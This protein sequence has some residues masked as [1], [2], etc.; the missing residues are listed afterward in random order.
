MTEQA[1]KP[2]LQQLLTPEDY[3]RLCMFYGGATVSIP[4]TAQGRWPRKPGIDTRI[5]LA[6]IL[7]IEGLR[8]VVAMLGGTKVYVPRPGFGVDRGERDI[9]IVRM[10]QCGATLAELATRFKITDRQV[11]NILNT[12]RS[13]R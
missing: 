2:L 12:H 5:R 11:R 7:S 1:E 4:K 9:Q 10:R 13:K 3:A 8:N 6:Q